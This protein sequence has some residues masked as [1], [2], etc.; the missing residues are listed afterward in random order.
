MFSHA[1]PHKMAK[2]IKS[3]T[4]FTRTTHRGVGEVPR[5]NS[6]HVHFNR[7]DEKRLKFT[8]VQQR[9]LSELK[10]ENKRRTDGASGC[11]CDWILSSYRPW[12]SSGTFQIDF[13]FPIDRPHRFLITALLKF[14][15]FVYHRSLVRHLRLHVFQESATNMLIRASVYDRCC[16]SSIL[17]W[18]IILTW[19][20][21]SLSLSD[22]CQRK[23]FPDYVLRN[24]A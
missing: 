1:V 19:K 6:L 16:C 14:H 22:N 23:I 8:T 9:K 21:G 17:P 11:G 2:S 12:L 15:Y 3:L 4:H 5:R 13:L 10:S 18:T 20:N 24:N 7:L